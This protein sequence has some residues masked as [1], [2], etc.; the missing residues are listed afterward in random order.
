MW[1]PN[2]LIKNCYTPC[3]RKKMLSKYWNFEPGIFKK[4]NFPD[5]KRQTCKIIYLKF[6]TFSRSR[7][8]NS[9]FKF[10]V[11]PQNFLLLHFYKFPTLDNLNF[12]LLRANLLIF[13]CTLKIKRKISFC[14]L[15]IDEFVE[16]SLL[17]VV[18]AFW[19]S[20]GC[21]CLKPE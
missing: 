5:P 21:V 7:E 12:N 9:R 14:F 11:P 17:G 16:F 3:K 15:R 10:L 19:I 18:I 4:S 20:D 6:I 8:F 1:V 2:F 13:F